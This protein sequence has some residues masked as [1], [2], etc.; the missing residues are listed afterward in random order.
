MIDC[1]NPSFLRPRV[2]VLTVVCFLA[3]IAGA[4]WLALTRVEQQTRLKSRKALQTVLRTTH[5]AMYVWLEN[6][7]YMTRMLAASSEV[8]SFTAAQLA[9]SRK[10]DDLRASEALKGLRRFVKPKLDEF[11]DLGIFLIAP[12]L[13]SIASM[14]DSNIGTRNLIANKRPQLLQRA[15][16]GETLL[17][18]TI[19][20]DVPLP[21]QSG[22]MVRQPPTLFLA[23]PIKNDSGQVLAVLTIRLDPQ[24]NF[25]RIAQLGRIGETGETYAFDAAATLIT[26]SRF[27]HHVRNI[28]LI[29]PN[30]KA[31]LRIQ[32]RDPGGNL[33]EGY[34]P[35][36]PAGT[37]PL[38]HMASEAIAGRSGTNVEGYGDYRGVSVF[39][40]WLWDDGLGFGLT[41][42]I[43]VTEAMAPYY[44]T[45][46]ILIAV[47]AFSALLGLVLSGL[48]ILLRRSNMIRLH[49]AYEELDERVRVRTAD[50][51]EAR[52]ELS[53]ANRELEQLA[54]RDALTGL[55]NRRVFEDFLEEEWRRCQRSKDTLA[56]AMID[57]D[58]F[59]NF[60]DTY[61]HQAGD[62]C[63]RQIA[64]ALKS[65]GHLAR[66]GDLIARY[67]GEEFVVVMGNTSLQD[68]A[69]VLEGV[70]EAVRAAAI[71]HG[72][73]RVENCEYVTISV[74]VAVLM[75]TPDQKPADL[76]ARADAALYSA[77]SAGRNQVAR[78]Q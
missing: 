65:T 48:L 34:Q 1:S 40:A 33:I 51:E 45:R 56:L 16:A 9:V 71:P 20:S 42:E 22:R 24:R 2:I 76:V 32:I 6:R 30:E 11:G 62:E 8:R 41:S 47:L 58:C 57:V 5:D 38:T 78:E 54:S 21:G 55:A 64:T 7:S 68:A 53:I 14:R 74:G 4:G 50:L 29:R 72:A 66:A 19:Q 31:I 75:P 10:P 43:D 69:T 23:T 15:F 36:A 28:G 18:P 77:K 46:L 44:A 60:N 12:D 13:I 25:T 39:G 27:D 67:G 35:S 49:Q 73:T 59:K 70:C 52:A 61:G 26:E 3:A 17:I 37:W 63:L